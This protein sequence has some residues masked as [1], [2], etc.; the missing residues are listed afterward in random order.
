MPY[1]KLRLYVQT[2]VHAWGVTEI[3]GVPMVFLVCRTPRSF[4]KATVLLGDDLGEILETLVTLGIGA[5]RELEE[6]LGPAT[7]AN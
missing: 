5:G 6:L 3:E 4:P 7:G 2:G 1:A